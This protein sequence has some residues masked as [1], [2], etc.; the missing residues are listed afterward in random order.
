MRAAEF[1]INIFYG[2]NNTETRFVRWPEKW[3]TDTSVSLTW[4]QKPKTSNISI[5]ILIGIKNIK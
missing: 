1:Q 4:T 5:F 2:M 3:V